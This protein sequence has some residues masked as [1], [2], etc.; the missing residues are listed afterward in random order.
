MDAEERLELIQL[1]A[2]DR[3]WDTIVLIGHKVL[4]HYYPA[5][6]FTGVS[7]DPGPVYVAALRKALEQIK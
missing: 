6:V 3:A 4:D 5:D 1:L 2:E 7:G